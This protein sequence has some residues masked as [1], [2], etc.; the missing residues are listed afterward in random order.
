MRVCT[1]VRTSEWELSVDLCTL[2]KHSTIE[3]HRQPQTNPS[4]YFC[5]FCRASDEVL[6]SQSPSTELHPSLPNA[7]F[8]NTLNIPTNQHTKNHSGSSKG[9]HSFNCILGG[10]QTEIN[11]IKMHQ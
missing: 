9:W 11:A 3:P 7:P 8:L 1:R 5:C 10:P 2:G 4:Y 6:A